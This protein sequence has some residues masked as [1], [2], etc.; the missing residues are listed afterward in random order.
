[1]DELLDEEAG[2]GGGG[3]VALV[4]L[5]DELLEAGG[6]PGAEDEGFGVDAG[7]EAVHAGYGL[8]RDRGGAMYCGTSGA[9][10]TRQGFRSGI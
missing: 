9:I 2:F 4:V 3:M 7:F 8:A 5:V 6:L 10:G 1:M